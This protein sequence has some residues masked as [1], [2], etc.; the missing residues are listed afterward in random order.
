MY[1]RQKTYIKILFIETETYLK[2]V[3]KVFFNSK[4]INIIMRTFQN[5]N[6]KHICFE[7][8]NKWLMWLNTS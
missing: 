7:K 5:K 8:K 3:L 2:F 4:K 6:A 1:D